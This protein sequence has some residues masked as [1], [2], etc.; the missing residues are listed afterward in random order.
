MKAVGIIA[1]Y[2][3][4]HNGHL[5]HLKKIKQMYPDS[6]IVL[7]L[8]GN[9]TE[10]GT[11][12]VLDK[13][14]KTKIALEEKIDLVIELPFIFAT[15]SADFFSHAA[16]QILETLKVDT[17]VFGS[18]TNDIDS[19]KTLAKTQIENED[20]D[21][22]VKVYLKLGENYPTA[23]SK[24]LFDLTG[25]KMTLPN[26]L[27]GISYVK[28]IIKNNYHIKPVCIKR[29]NDY[30]EK[31]I[32]NSITSATSIR[33]ALKNNI[34]IKNAVPKSTYKY[35]KETPLHFQDDYFKF[36]KYKILTE[37]DLNIFQTVDEGLGDKI[38]K[39]ILNSTN[40]D[41]LIKNVK[42]KRYTY[43][44][45][46]RCLNHILCDIKKS[47]VKNMKDIEYIRILGFSDKGKKYINKIKKDVKIPIIGNFTKYNS[48]MLKLELKVSSIYASTL[49]EKEKNEFIKEEYR[50]HP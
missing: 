13:F 45:I 10:R 29:T 39:E 47:D 21:K 5:Y 42:S 40:Y 44:K 18:E 49:N 33:E 2:N 50:H 11:P 34:E 6:I 23:L 48:D 3:P 30:H 27:L 24:S 7:V 17:L 1:E 9:F 14:T 46:N 19:F 20:F 31:E 28:E 22:L 15:Q 36:L 8:G 38:K 32:N 12:S 35:L 26:D 25:K 43:N 4:F 37:Q 16:L 41:E